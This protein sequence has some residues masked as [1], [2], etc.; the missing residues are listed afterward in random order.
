M[1]LLKEHPSIKILQE[2]VLKKKINCYLVGGYLRDFL[3][4]RPCNDFDFALEHRAIEIARLFASKIKGAFVLLDKEHGCARVVKKS[5]GGLQTFDFADY[6]KK[7]FKEDLGARDF[8]INTLSVS[9]NKLSIALS[10]DRAIEDHK[11]AKADIKSKSIR[12][13]KANVFVEDPLR[14]LRAFS[15]KAALR[16]KI[17]PQTLARIKKDKD[18]IRSV[19][20]ERIRDEL[21]KILDTPR[22]AENLQAMDRIGLLEKVM[23]QIT[24]MYGVKQGGYHHLDV[25]PHSLE[26]VRQL[27]KVF[28][29]IRSQPEV[30]DYVN[31]ALVTPRRRLALMKLAALLHDVGKPATRKKEKARYSFHGHEHV[32]RSIVRPLAKQ[33]KLSTQER[34][35]LEDMVLWHL[36]PGYL[37]NFQNPSARAVFRYFR[38]TKNEA[39]SILLLSLADQRSTRGPLTTEA[40][41]KHHEKICL[42][43]LIRYFEKKKEKPL[44]RLIDGHDLIK[45]LK[46]QPSPLF[47]KILKA[48]EEQQTLKKISTR[49]E[50]LQ[51]AR[52]I[53]EKG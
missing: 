20:C 29:E 12:M 10:L 22:A 5:A 51:L 23:P 26:T 53:V 21:F 4:G 2:L 32:G 24:V 15:L 40:D 49:P 35:A 14:L 1:F 17:E 39:A 18:L 27:E 13:T 19:S 37:S 42:G 36:R 33:L 7:T 38:D 47:G 45:K 41:Q 6:R 28:E 46:L 44:E 52:K 48:I 30:I 34:H 50:A 3:M 31:E 25:W 43:L 8:T 16:F 11:K 9:I